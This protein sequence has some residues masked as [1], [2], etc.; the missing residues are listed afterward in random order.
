MS[1]VMNVASEL[2]KLT[3]IQKID[4]EI[5]NLKKRMSSLPGEKDQI[6]KELES[7]K[8]AFNEANDS[9]KEITVLKNE[10]ETEMKSKEEQIKKLDGDLLQIKNN[11]EYSALQ[12][13]ING[14][15]ADVS[16]L[17]EEIIKLYDEI[18]QAE[19]RVKEE[20]ERFEKEK[21]QAEIA[22][23][24]LAGLENE[25]NAK[26]K[27]LSDKRGDFSKKIDTEI[28]A[29]YERILSNRGE[30]ALAFVKDG[31]C[32]QCNMQLRPQVINST[33]IKKEI[34]TCESCGRILYAKE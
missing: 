18:Q 20:K 24:K 22:K 15:K 31:F 26:L 33:K 32:A 7:K 16:I 23:N 30:R 12:N 19:D 25:I 29:V 28:F 10:K 27:E 6:E 14:I 5:Y 13:E 8:S 9:L 17:E 11:K 1:E 4:S 3:E 34:I 21:E 2:Q